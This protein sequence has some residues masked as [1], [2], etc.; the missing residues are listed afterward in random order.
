MTR[1]HNMKRA[2]RA[3][4]KVTG[5]RYTVARS[6][7]V[8]ASPPPAP[9]KTS[10]SQGEAMPA[11]H[12]DF[13]AELDEQGFAILRSFAT[14]DELERINAVVDEVITAKINDVRDESE[15][16]RAAGETGWIDAWHPGPG[17]SVSE[18]V[19]ERTDVAWI[20]EHP[21]LLEIRALAMGDLPKMKEAAFRSKFHVVGVSASLPGYGHQGFHADDETPSPPI[22]SWDGMSF[23]FVLNRQ[24]AELGTMR[25][26]PGSHRV[27]LR[28]R[29]V[30]FG[31]AMPPQ[32][33]EIRMEADPGDLIIHSNHLWKSMTP[34]PAP[35]SA[36]ISGFDPGFLLRRGDPARPGDDER[37]E[38]TTILVSNGA[39]RSLTRPDDP[40]V[41]SLRV[42]FGYCT[43]GSEP[44]SSVATAT[45]NSTIESRVGL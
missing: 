4:M 35:R 3:R 9:A 10:S 1:D 19:T 11:A 18:I 14:S 15:R 42:G 7:L 31:S 37:R 36:G 29:L 8:D 27:P 17:G 43:H 12:S 20:R 34:T 32:P 16:R 25:A 21:R 28:P 26:V 39:R 5:E 23:I 40:H 2:T 44:T 33:D 22:G 24:D 38:S 30:E 45:R 13:L 6:A 41:A